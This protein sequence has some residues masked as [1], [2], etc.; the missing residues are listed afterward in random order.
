MNVYAMEN[1]DGVAWS[2][3]LG[4]G[5]FHKASRFG[6]VEFVTQPAAAGAVAAAEGTPAANTAP[7][8]VVEQ[9]KP[10]TTA[11]E[12]ANKEGLSVSKKALQQ[13]PAPAAPAQP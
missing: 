13:A 5:N 6:Q 3:I 4:A 1:N 8:A 9:P 11:E 2:P 7:A 10:G 12:P